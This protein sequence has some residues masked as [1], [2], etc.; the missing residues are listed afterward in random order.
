M[1]RM[2][3]KGPEMHGLC[4]SV[5]QSWDQ[6]SMLSVVDV[7]LMVILCRKTFSEV[8][9]HQMAPSSGLSVS[10]YVRFC[11]RM[12][13]SLALGPTVS[14]S[15]HHWLWL[16]GSRQSPAGGSPSLSADTC[17]LLMPGIPA[18]R[19]GWEERAG[20]PGGLLAVLPTYRFACSWNSS[21]ACS[22]SISLEGFRGRVAVGPLAGAWHRPLDSREAAHQ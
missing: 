17:F 5:L 1:E 2:C 13:D 19:R 11:T 15:S 12:S 22:S 21:P 8:C 18:G 6:T 20:P 16:A 7:G 14:C 3:L 4:L 9:L 10:T